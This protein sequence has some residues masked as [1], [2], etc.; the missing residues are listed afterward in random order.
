MEHVVQFLEV[1][2]SNPYVIWA[3]GVW[4]RRLAF[5]GLTFASMLSMAGFL[6]WRETRAESFKIRDLI[7][8]AFRASLS[9][10]VRSVTIGSVLTTLLLNK[11]MNLGNRMVQFY[12]QFFVSAWSMYYLLYYGE[13]PVVRFKKSLFNRQLV[14]KARLTQTYW[15]CIWLTQ[16]DA[17]TAIGAAFGDLEFLL[18]Y[19]LHLETHSLMSYDGVNEVKLD[20]YI[21]QQRGKTLVTKSSAD[22]VV[23]LVHGLGGSSQEAYLRKFASD[24]HRKGWRACSY[25]WWRLDFGEWRDLDIVIR[26]IAKENPEAPIVVVSFSA[27][28]HIALRYLQETGKNSQLVAAVCV[29]PCQDLM[30][31]YGKMQQNP[32]R[33]VYQNFVDRTLVKMAVRSYENDKRTH[34]WKREGYKAAFE[35]EIYCDRLYDRTIFNSITYSSQGAPGVVVSKPETRGRDRPMFVGTEDHYLGVA[36]GKWDKIGV[37]TMVMHAHDDPILLYDSID[38]DAVCENKNIIA[39]TTERGGHVAWH[40]GLL[41][42][43]PTWSHRKS[44]DFVNA[45]LEAHATTNFILQVIHSASSL[46]AERDSDVA[47]SARIARICSSTDLDSLG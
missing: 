43:G 22:P 9:K 13:A 1:N 3:R 14:Q 34:P 28:T 30:A 15:P 47:P 35:E 25:D 29:S 42:I 12:L 38:W 21:P 10:R 27:G 5:R 36:K 33:K 18:F 20:W 39:V 16:A 32:R 8:I 31:E 2:L 19:D 44:L 24:S 37:T 7:A 23:V 26:H 4:R 41:P 46:D 6:A 40:E 11:F 45:V 17:M